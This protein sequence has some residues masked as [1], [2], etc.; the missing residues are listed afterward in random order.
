[1]RW[2]YLGGVVRL[3]AVRV[4]I[5]GVAQVLSRRRIAQQGVAHVLQHSGNAWSARKHRPTA[6]SRARVL[7]LEPK[8]A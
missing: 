2:V 8:A 7:G 6:K 1:M 4:R 5:V 3:L